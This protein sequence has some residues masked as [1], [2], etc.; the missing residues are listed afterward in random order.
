MDINIKHLKRVFKY[1]REIIDRRLQY[2]RGNDDEIEPAMIY[3]DT[4]F[5]GNVQK[6][7]NTS[8]YVIL[9]IM[10]IFSTMDQKAETDCHLNNGSRVHNCS[11]VL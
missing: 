5:A 7:Q 2:L 1:L 6:R 8:G 11:K 10:G 9:Y 3:S 4:D